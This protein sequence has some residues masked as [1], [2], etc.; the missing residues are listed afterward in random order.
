M[1]K[2]IN[3]FNIKEFSKKVGIIFQENIT[4]NISVRQLVS[5]GRFTYVGLFSNL[6]SDD[7]KKIEKALEITNTK[8]FE[9]MKINELSSGQ[10]Q[11]VWIALLISQ[12]VK[13]LF[14]DEP[15]TFLDLKHQFEI[16]DCLV[17]LNKFE[18]KTIIMILHDINLAVQYADNI[19][20]MKSG[21]IIDHGDPKKIITQDMINEVFEINAKIIN[22]GD[23]IFCFPLK[24]Y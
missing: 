16:L 12:D 24:K 7:N 6:T 19:I 21:K 22:N 13:Y 17:K 2:N 11:L 9:N 4:P 10:K 20:I 1:K 15:T 3:L 18:N 8:C 14:L 23:D 5:Y